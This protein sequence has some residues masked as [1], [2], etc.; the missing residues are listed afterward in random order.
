MK[1]IC[2]F[3]F[4]QNFLRIKILLI[5]SFALFISLTHSL[6]HTFSVSISFVLMY[7]VV[8][9]ICCSS[10]GISNK[11]VPKLNELINSD[12]MLENFNPFYHSVIQYSMS[13]SSLSLSMILSTV[14]QQEGRLCNL[15]K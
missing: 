5:A 8:V 14:V 2:K 15:I 13:F 6:T 3:G 10:S 9:S 4:D 1:F 7:G 12:S 11:R